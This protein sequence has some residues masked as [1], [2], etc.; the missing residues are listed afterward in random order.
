MKLTKQQAKLVANIETGNVLCREYSQQYG[1]HF[2]W[3]HGGENPCREVVEPLIGGGVL[4]L[5]NDGLFGDGQTYR[6]K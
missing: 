6:L 5:A 3:A 2:Y 1:D 4:E